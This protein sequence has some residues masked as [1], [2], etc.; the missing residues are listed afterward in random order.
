MLT[1]YGVGYGV[2]Y[3]ECMTPF[4]LQDSASTQEIV[5][6]PWSMWAHAA[7]IKGREMRTST[8][9]TEYKCGNNPFSISN[10]AYLK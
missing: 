9:W 3:Q 4:F 1:N 7:E 5:T 8:H 6:L 2:S 10:V